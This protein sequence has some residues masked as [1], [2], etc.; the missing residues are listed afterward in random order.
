MENI[1]RLK[2]INF[3]NAV[4]VSVS[5]LRSKKGFVLIPTETVYGL[6]CLWD[7]IESKKLIYKAKTRPEEKPFQM[8]V[9]SIDMAIK[10]GCCLNHIAIKLANAFCPGPIT[11]IVPC[12][13]NK[14]AV[15]FRIPEHL[16]VL[17]LLKKL[18]SPL[19]ATSANI[20]GEAPALS[21]Y[22]TLNS[23][24]IEP[25]LAIDGGGLPKNSLAS[26][27]IKI[28]GENIKILRE[29]VISSDDIEKVLK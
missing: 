7:D 13:D 10:Y 4:E 2:D 28:E 22:D 9:A 11:I 19:A 12:V 18:N 17:S 23:L 24:K 20:S 29:G 15:G 6:A 27:V 5:A 1:I 3:D 26:T 14:T 16:F 21:A 25:I 8:L